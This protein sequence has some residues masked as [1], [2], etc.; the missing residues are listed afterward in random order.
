VVAAGERER[1]LSTRIVV[2]VDE[3]DLVGMAVLL[4]LHGAVEEDL[5]RQSK[6]NG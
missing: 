3:P 1:R 5:E 2:S 4:Q 6:G